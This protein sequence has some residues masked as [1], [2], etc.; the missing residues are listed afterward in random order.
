MNRFLSS[1]RGKVF[2]NR[3]EE[4]KK[5]SGIKFTKIEKYI[6]KNDKFVDIDDKL[7]LRILNYIRNKSLNAYIY[8]QNSK[9]PFGNSR[10]DILICSKEFFI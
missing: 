2:N 3:W 10:E 6:S 7:I 1:E 5:E 8:E 4:R 9:L